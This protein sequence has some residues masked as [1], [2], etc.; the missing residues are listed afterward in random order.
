[1]FWLEPPSGRLGGVMD[2]QEMERFDAA[3]RDMLQASRGSH[4]HLFK[5]MQHPRDV[6]VEQFEVVHLE[7]TFLVAYPNPVREE[8][9]VNYYL[10]EEKAGQL[11]LTDLQGKTLAETD[12]TFD[13]SQRTLDFSTYPEGVYFLSLY[14]DGK[15]I[16]VIKV[17]KF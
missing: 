14:A 3:I 7:E 17:V 10:A 12:L 16:E 11:R 8:L 9:V 15:P 2:S 4:D 1:M 5:S 6:V 13:N